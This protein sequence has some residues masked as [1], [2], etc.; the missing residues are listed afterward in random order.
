VLRVLVAAFLVAHGLVHLGIWV[1][2]KDPI[3]PAPFDP[4][5]SWIVS[6]H[7]GEVAA[8]SVSVALGCAIA[9]TFC[10]A[11]WM[12]LLS[13]SGTGGLLLLASVTA[14]ALKALWFHPWL[15]LGVAI[16]I[17]IVLAVLVGWPAS[18]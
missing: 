6:P 9:A 14:L 17:A 15:V 12:V 5:H 10:A 11:G 13:A 18:L 8:R 2:P 16:D 4:S 3:R 1:T 7:S